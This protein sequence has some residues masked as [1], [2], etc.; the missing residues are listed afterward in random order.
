MAPKELT[1]KLL[2]VLEEITHAKEK[3]LQRQTA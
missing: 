1:E 2:S 3:T